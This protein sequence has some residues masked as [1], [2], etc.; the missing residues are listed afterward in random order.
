MTESEGD[1][2]AIFNLAIALL[3]IFTVHQEDN[4][5]IEQNLNE[6][7]CTQQSRQANEVVI[8]DC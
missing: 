3:Y 7:N 1:S 8:H 2:C 5:N 4:D 6:R